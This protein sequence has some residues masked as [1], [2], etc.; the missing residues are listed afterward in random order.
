[1]P[2]TTVPA[3][4]HVKLLTRSRSSRAILTRDDVTMGDVGVPQSRHV[5]SPRRPRPPRRTWPATLALLLHVL[6]IHTGPHSS[7]SPHPAACPPRPRTPPGGVSSLPEPHPPI[8]WSA[9]E[10]RSP[11]ASPSSPSARVLS[12][13]KCSARMISKPAASSVA[14]SANPG[15]IWRVFN[16]L[17][18]VT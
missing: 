18:V 12:S 6:T 7:P 3:P 11:R 14:S 4:I 13:R 16:V 8:I 1:M 10:P 17:V 5:D 2:T 15:C 9:V